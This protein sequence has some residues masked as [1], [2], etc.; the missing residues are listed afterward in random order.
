[1]PVSPEEAKHCARPIQERENAMRLRILTALAVLVSAYVHLKLWL[2]GFRHLDKIGP[3][4]MANVIGGVVIALL[5]IVWQHWL[6]PLLAIGFG[7]STLG[8]F[9]I[10]STRGLFGLHEHWEGWTVWTAAGAEVV[11]IVAGAVVLMHAWQARSAASAES[12]VTLRR[13]QMH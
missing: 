7:I 1:M 8:A 2:D 12:G 10:S 13:P 5:L 11:A 4:F 9:I 6:P 3:A